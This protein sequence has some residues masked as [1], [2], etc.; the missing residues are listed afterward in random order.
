MY[1]ARSFMADDRLS[2]TPLRCLAYPFLYLPFFVSVPDL[3][4][5]PSDSR[6]NS[7]SF[8][9]RK[10]GRGD[11]AS[12]EISSLGI[13]TRTLRISPISPDLYATFAKA[14]MKTGARLAAV[15]CPC[16]QRTVCVFRA[17]SLSQPPHHRDGPRWKLYGLGRIIGKQ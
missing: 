2:P 13:C 14:T 6:P 5:E 8:F 10:N 3:V 17:L 12:F 15:T 9:T 4:L 7:A 1:H 16:A 11:D